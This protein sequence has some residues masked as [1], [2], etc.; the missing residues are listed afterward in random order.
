MFNRGWE[1]GTT[2]SLSYQE[3]QK[4]EGLGIASNTIPFFQRRGEELVRNRATSF[5]RTTYKMQLPLHFKAS[6]PNF[7]L[8]LHCR[9]KHGND[10][11][12]KWFSNFSFSCHRS[13]V[14]LMDKDL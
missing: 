9:D 12:M 2:F 14:Q 13:T 8:L 6:F 1:W 5:E 4:I 7:I 3:F 10:T 11:V